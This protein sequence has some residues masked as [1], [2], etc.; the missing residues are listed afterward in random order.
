M[1]IITKYII[2]QSW[3]SNWM[4][5]FRVNQKWDPSPFFSKI[6]LAYQPILWLYDP[7]IRSTLSSYFIIA[8]LESILIVVDLNYIELL[9]LRIT[10][11]LN[12]DL[13]KIKYSSDLLFNL[14][15]FITFCFKNRYAITSIISHFLTNSGK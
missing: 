6:Y 13:S 10:Y 8:R 14:S 15:N 5:H 7:L 1:V 11:V 2:S 4:N 12:R 9:K 3:S